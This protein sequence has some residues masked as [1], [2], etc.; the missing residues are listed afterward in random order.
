MK[1]LFCFCYLALA[2]STS[3]YAADSGLINLGLVSR[4]V[5]IKYNSEACFSKITANP[6]NSKLKKDSAN[7]NY[8]EIRVRIDRIIYQLSADMRYSNSVKIYKRLNKYYQTHDFGESGTVKGFIE[9]YILAFKDLDL[10]CRKYLNSEQPGATKGII[11]TAAA[12]SIIETGWTIAKN[13]RDMQGK[14]VDGVIE[15]LNNL[16]L[17]SPQELLKTR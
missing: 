2:F 7:A 13:I 10:T 6:A 8:N 17:N 4:L 14:K 16:R 12:L 15:L 1:N 11:T 9:P 5:E 3:G